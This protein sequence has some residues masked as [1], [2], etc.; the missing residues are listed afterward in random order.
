M[1]DRI[2]DKLIKQGSD[3][4]QIQLYRQYYASELQRIQRNVTSK[5]VRN[6]DRLEYHFDGIDVNLYPCQADDFMHLMVNSS[7]HWL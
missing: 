7:F 4:V 1:Y 6:F 3:D 5:L 2:I